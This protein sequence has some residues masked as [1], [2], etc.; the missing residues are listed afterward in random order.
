MVSNYSQ[1]DLTFTALGDATRRAII[2]RLA[3]GHA[4]VNEVA[5]PFG[6]SRPAVSKHLR[7]LERAN[8][9]HLRREGRTT[10]CQLDAIPLQE[11]ADWVEQYRQFWESMLEPLARYAES[12]FEV[13][14]SLKNTE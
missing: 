5:L 3:L 14:P 7:I 12:G 11:A 8:L 13:I 9:V 2:T 4:T 1:I 10:I 6:I